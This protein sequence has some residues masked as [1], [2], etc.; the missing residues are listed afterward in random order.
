MCY[1]II[2]DTDTTLEI[3]VISRVFILYNI[4]LIKCIHFKPY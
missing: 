2:H 3:Y 1:C 4:N